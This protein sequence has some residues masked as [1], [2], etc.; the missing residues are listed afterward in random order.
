MVSIN[1]N[2]LQFYCEMKFEARNPK[3][4]TNP[5]DQNLNVPNYPSPFPSPHWGEGGGEGG[6]GF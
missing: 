1:Q 3:Y 5:N 4:E 6:F 2:R